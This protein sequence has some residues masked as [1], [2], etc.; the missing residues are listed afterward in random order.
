MTGI[1]IWMMNLNLNLVLILPLL[2][3]HQVCRKALYLVLFSFLIYIDGLAEI[4]LTSGS[5]SMLADD[6]LLYKVV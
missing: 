3:S 6:A 5:P 4:P 1:S 2:M